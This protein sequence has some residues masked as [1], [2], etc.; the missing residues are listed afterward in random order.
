MSEDQDE[1]TAFATA[2]MAESSAAA[3]PPAAQPAEPVAAE[4][5]PTTEATKEEPTVEASPAKEEPPAWKVA[6]EKERAARAA[7]QTSKVE[8]K[9]KTEL[10][11]LQSRLAKYEAIEAKKATNPL[12]AAEELG[13]SYENLTKEY[14]K[15]LEPKPDE[16][17]EKYNSL[18]QKLQHVETL[19]QQQ[20]ERIEQEAQAKAVN[21][22]N[23]DVKAVLESKG[24]EF[25][26]VRA[27]RQ[28]PEL[29]REIVAAHFR[30][31]ATFDS[32]GR[33]VAPGEIMATEQACGLAEKYLDDD[34]GQFRST[35]KFTGKVEAPKA[36]PK[37]PATQT[38]SQDLRQAT[39]KSEP[40]GDEIEQLLLLKKTLEA[41]LNTQG[42]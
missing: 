11:A 42:N 29:V 6:A 19:L 31:T 14:I 30:A 13:L 7:K 24:E 10:Q 28:G 1:F 25:E 18:N 33:L 34:L 9:L 5:A 15:T 8:A 36:A 23:A 16:A 17:T 12:A 40:H 39:T 35:K 4:A 38:L 27:A 22:F 3:E 21:A 20:Q 32:S 26:L 2:A 37:P 41:Q